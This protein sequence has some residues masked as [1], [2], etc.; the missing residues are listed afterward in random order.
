MWSG[1]SLPRDNVFCT[2][3]HQSVHVLGPV[4]LETDSVFQF[5][6][7]EI[8]ILATDSFDSKSVSKIAVFQYLVDCCLIIRSITHVMM[9]CLS[10]T[11]ESLTTP[12]LPPTQEMAMTL[13]ASSCGLLGQILTKPTYAFWPEVTPVRFDALWWAWWLFSWWTGNIWLCCAFLWKHIWI[14]R[15]ISN[16]SDV[17]TGCAQLGTQFVG[18]QSRHEALVTKIR[19]H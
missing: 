11:E 19:L 13:T 6:V 9:W 7:C 4:Q 1:L 17:P 12:N 15:R 16:I 18:V 5:R 3:F 10:V 14:I 8:D 2:T